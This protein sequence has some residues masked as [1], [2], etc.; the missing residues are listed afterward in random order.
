MSEFIVIA[1]LSMYKLENECFGAP[2]NMENIICVLNYHPLGSLQ[3]YF[4]DYYS[5]TIISFKRDGHIVIGRWYC[6]KWM[7]WQKVAIY[8][9]SNHEKTNA[10]AHYDRCSTQNHTVFFFS[11]L[12]LAL[13]NIC[14]FDGDA[15]ALYEMFYIIKTDACVFA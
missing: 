15:K 2:L 11:A 9:K 3:K 1:R 6:L 13:T 7:R 10:I 4:I 5:S 8:L 14:A 12:S